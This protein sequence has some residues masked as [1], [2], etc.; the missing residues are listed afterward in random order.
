[1]NRGMHPVEIAKSIKL[2]PSLCVSPFLQTFQS[3]P[4]WSSRTV[5][6]SYIGWFSGNPEELFPLTPTER[7]KMMV[8]SF[9]TKK[10]SGL[11]VIATELH[12]FFG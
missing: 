5:F 8:D 7:G 1:M 4:E 3:T 11:N 9:G 12:L 6:D 10:A 2:P